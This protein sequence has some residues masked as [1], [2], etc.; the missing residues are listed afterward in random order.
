MGTVPFSDLTK[1]FTEEDRRIVEKTKE[2]LFMEYEL[3]AQLRKDCD[4]TQ[5]ELAEILEIRQ[6]AISKIEN[7]E[8]VLVKTLE[9]YIRALG[10]ELEIRAKFPNK[11]VTLSQFTGRTAA[12]EGQPR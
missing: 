5:K 8:D 11:I 2:V 6:A 10:G 4:L 3:V 12:R 7:Q 9:R 1:H